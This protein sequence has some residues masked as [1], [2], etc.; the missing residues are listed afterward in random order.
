MATIVRHVAEG[1]RLI[2]EKNGVDLSVQLPSQPVPVMGDSTRL[3]QIVGN[4]L[5]NANKFSDAGG[6]VTVRLVEEPTGEAPNCPG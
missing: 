3:A 6:Q 2:L 1:R 5:D 4:L